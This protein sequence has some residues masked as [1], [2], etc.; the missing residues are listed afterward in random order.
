M[1][2]D[3]RV[4]V[5]ASWVLCSL[6][7][8]AKRLPLNTWVLALSVHAICNPISHIITP[9]KSMRKRNSHTSQEVLAICGSLFC[10]SC[11][12]GKTRC[13]RRCVCSSQH[14]AQ[15]QDPRIVYSHANPELCTLPRATRFLTRSTLP[16]TYP[17]ATTS[18]PRG[19]A[20]PPSQTSRDLPSAMPSARR[21]V[22]EMLRDSSGLCGAPRN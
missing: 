20:K 8:K 3:K 1:K 4:A 5:G 9:R 17:P 6:A 2:I 7:F 19:P 18:V 15:D 12:L 14:P 22:H 11:G 10:F 16:T 21:A 13:F